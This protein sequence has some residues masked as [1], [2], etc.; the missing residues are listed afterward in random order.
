MSE[1]PRNG[2]NIEFKTSPEGFAQI[3]FERSTMPVV[4]FMLLQDAGSALAQSGIADLRMENTSPTGR[5]VPQSRWTFTDYTVPTGDEGENQSGFFGRL[6]AASYIPKVAQHAA[7]L[8]RETLRT[9]IQD[10]V[11]VFEAHP[12]AFRAF[13][14]LAQK[15]EI[16]NDRSAGSIA[17]M[18]LEQAIGKRD[19]TTALALEE[20][21][22]IIEFFLEHFD[23]NP[24]MAELVLHSQSMYG[25]AAFLSHME[26][27]LD[28][29]LRGGGNQGL[30]H[31]VRKLYVEPLR[32][33]AEGYEGES[34]NKPA[35]EHLLTL[36]RTY[37][38]LAQ[39]QIRIGVRPVEAVR[40]EIQ[41][42]RLQLLKTFAYSDAKS[43]R[44]EFGVFY[45]HES[46]SVDAKLLLF[47]LL[48]DE[49]DVRVP[50][51]YLKMHPHIRSTIQEVI[52]NKTFTQ[53]ATQ[54]KAVSE[55]LKKKG[56]RSDVNMILRDFIY[57]QKIAYSLGTDETRIGRNAYIR[58]LHRA[59]DLYTVVT[60]EKGSSE[61]GVISDEEFLLGLFESG[62]TPD[63][64]K[65][66]RIFRDVTPF[67]SREISSS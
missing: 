35:Q 13:S 24:R 4:D 44:H 55:L 62:S 46:D 48:K 5:G 50:D 38:T 41:K 57:Q 23:R 11:N 9:I 2:D 59:L 7:E 33:A 63:E 66:H 25:H 20:F 37:F 28:A 21:P 60:R 52:V 31:R 36:Y 32:D 30:I 6:I 42:I 51:N 64:V 29:A 53:D 22:S 43:L 49:A 17:L 1:R 56:T 65:D 8:D 19:G 26:P 67:Q 47:S 16:A 40:D 3:Q 12:D 10:N 15:V 14:R 34:S 45:E 18:R 54:R 58:I 61:S 27:V 39:E